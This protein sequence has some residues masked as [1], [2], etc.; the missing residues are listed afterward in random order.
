MAP[1]TSKLFFSDMSSYALAM[2]DYKV[3]YFA[4]EIFE[5]LRRTVL[6]GWVLLIPTEKTFLRLVCAQ[7]QIYPLLY[8][9]SVPAVVDIYVS[10]SRCS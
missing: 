5:L 9:L 6:T 7:A 3:D 1:P 2:Q 10:P 4:W 8:L